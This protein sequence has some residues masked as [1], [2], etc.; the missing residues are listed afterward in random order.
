ML[1]C[2]QPVLTCAAGIVLQ[3]QTST[4]AAAE[5]ESR[6]GA[7]PDPKE[8][9]QSLL[10]VSSAL[11]RMKMPNLLSAICWGTLLAGDRQQHS[12]TSPLP[13][14]PLSLLPRLLLTIAGPRSLPVHKCPQTGNYEQ[15]FVEALQAQ[16]LSVMMWVLEQTEPGTV[17]GSLTQVVLISVIQQLGHDLSTDAVRALPQILAPWGYHRHCQSAHPPAADRDP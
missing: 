13:P 3:M 11:G 7:S 6:A 4:R 14:P 1:T 17:F 9:I 10:E 16:S 15:A 12:S 2:Y 8:I 5:A